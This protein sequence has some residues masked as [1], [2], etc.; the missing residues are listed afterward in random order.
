MYVAG[1]RPRTRKLDVIAFE[2]GLLSLWS[3]RLHTDYKHV[4]TLIPLP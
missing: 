2:A 4:Q 3:K 1:Q